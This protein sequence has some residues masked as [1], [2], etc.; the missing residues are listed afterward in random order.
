VDDKIIERFWA[1]VNKDGPIPEHC[2]ELGKCWVWKQLNIEAVMVI[3][4]VMETKLQHTDFLG[5]Y[6]IKI[7]ELRLFFISVITVC[8]LDPITYS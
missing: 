8:V 6:T 4:I 2:S 5:N 7:L 1:K 3:L